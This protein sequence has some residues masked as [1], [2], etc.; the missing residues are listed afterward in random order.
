MKLGVTIAWRS[1]CANHHASL[2]SVL[3]PLRAFTSCGLAS[4]TWTT[5]SRMLNTGFQ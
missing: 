2:A 3:C 4:A 1:K 5:P